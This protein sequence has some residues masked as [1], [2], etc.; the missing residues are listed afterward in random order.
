MLETNPEFI[1]KAKRGTQIK[2]VL[3]LVDTIKKAHP[4]AIIRVEVEV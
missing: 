1:I 2:D 3:Y 4:N